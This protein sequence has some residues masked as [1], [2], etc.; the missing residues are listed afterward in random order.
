M[1]LKA[2]GGLKLREQHERVAE[3]RAALAIGDERLVSR[4]YA[5]LLGL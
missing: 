4:G 2:H 1:E 5:A 3:L